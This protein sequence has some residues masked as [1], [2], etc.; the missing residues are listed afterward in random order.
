MRSCSSRD[1]CQTRVPGSSH[2]RLRAGLAGGGPSVSP[3]VLAPHSRGQACPVVSVIC[4]LLL[5][6][7]LGLG[8]LDLR[9]GRF[10]PPGVE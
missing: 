4:P 10:Q 9:D 2:S 8:L 6:Q 5:L 1:G 3:Q 7:L